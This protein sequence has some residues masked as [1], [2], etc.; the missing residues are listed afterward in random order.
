MTHSE[1]GKGDDVRPTDHKKFSDGYD[2]IWG[3]KKAKPFFAACDRCG[4]AIWID[5]NDSYSGI[6]TCTPKHVKE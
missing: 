1:A 4:K 2:L 5:P 6:H 3:K